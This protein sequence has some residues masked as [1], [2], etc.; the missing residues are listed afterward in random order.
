MKKRHLQIFI[1]V[2]LGA[3]PKAFAVTLTFEECRQKLLFKN[4]EIEIAKIDEKISELDLNKSY[5]DLL[6]T[7]SLNT[8]ASDRTLTNEDPSKRIFNQSLD[9]S[10]N[11][12]NGFQDYSKIITQRLEIQKSKTLRLQKEKNQLNQL[13]K[14]YSDLLM[15]QK[16]EAYYR[17]SVET[18]K[19]IKELVALK[20]S[21][22]SETKD[23]VLF[24]EGQLEEA[25][26]DLELALLNLSSSRRQLSHLLDDSLP[27][28][29]YVDESLPKI[30]IPTIQS[31]DYTKLLLENSDYKVNSIEQQISEQSLKAAQGKFLPTVDLTISKEIERLRNYSETQFEKTDSNYIKLTVSIPLMES[32]SQSFEYKKLKAEKLKSEIEREQLKVSLN[33]KYISLIEKNQDLLKKKEIYQKFLRASQLREEIS[34]AKYKMGLIKFDNWIDAQ[35]SYLS[36]QK[37]VIENENEIQT[38]EAEF[39][40]LAEGVL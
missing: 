32:L 10:F 40:S 22:G 31:M 37:T 1:L 14:I 6:P 4:R 38:N 33:E 29:F 3:Y 26:A 27:S 18:R 34:T 25:N 16:K 28:D 8:F 11:I 12:F 35:D 36:Y 2:A 30:N 21:S 13:K 20:F 9:L 7:L 19:N 17:K 23:S 24:S 39:E 15:A 5:S